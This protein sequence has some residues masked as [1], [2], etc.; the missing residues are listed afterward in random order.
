MT[1]KILILKNDRAGDLFTSITLISSLITRYNDIKIYLSELN[2]GF[3]FFFKG[4]KINKINFNLS[5]SDKFLI[6]FDILFSNYTKIYILTPKNF[7]FF[8]PY[9]FRNIKFYAIVYDGKRN[10]RP[11]KYLRNFLYKYKVIYRNKVNKKS[12]R[13]LQE[14]LIDDDLILDIKHNGLNIPKINENFKN[15][16]PKKFILFQ[17]RYLFFE[18]LGWNINDFNYLMLQLRTKYKYILFSSDIENNKKSKFY[19]EYFN[20]HYSVIDSLNLIKKENLNNKNIFYLKNINSENLFY[21]LNESVMNLAKDGLYCHVSFFLQKKCH[22]L[23]NF[24]IYCKDDIKHERISY[25]EWYKGMNYS[26]SFLN[27]DIKKASKKIIK[28]I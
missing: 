22:N 18:Q 4:K 3:S 13:Q 10:N 27:N 12:Y 1:D 15:I 26:F 19:N 17:F 6:F 5:V 21:V 9:I 7:Y 20:N 16:L 14:E 28:N 25:S 11:S 8:L 24:K 2:Y 23:F